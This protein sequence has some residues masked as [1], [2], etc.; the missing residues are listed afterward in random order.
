MGEFEQEVG[1]YFVLYG[2]CSPPVKFTMMSVVEVF[3]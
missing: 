3:V 2:V 1:K